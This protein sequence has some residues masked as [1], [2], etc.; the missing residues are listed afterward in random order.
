MDLQWVVAFC[1]ARFPTFKAFAFLGG[2]T[3]LSGKGPRKADAEL[4]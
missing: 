4:R 1:L 2:K 3:S